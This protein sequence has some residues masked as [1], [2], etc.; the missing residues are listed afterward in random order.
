MFALNDG[1]SSSRSAVQWSERRG[2]IQETT[3]LG[4]VAAVHQSINHSIKYCGFVWRLSSKVPTGA[5][6]SM[7]ETGFVRQHGKML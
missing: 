6:Y 5:V 4:A 2:A 1:H 7:Q 3:I